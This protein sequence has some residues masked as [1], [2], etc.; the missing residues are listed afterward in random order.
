VVSISEAWFSDDKLWNLVLSWHKTSLLLNYWQL[1]GLLPLLS[2]I[3]WLNSKR[4][5]S[6]LR[7]LGGFVALSILDAFLDTALLLLL[8]SYLLLSISLRI[9]EEWLGFALGDH[10]LLVI[11][12]ELSWK[13]R[14]VLHVH[15]FVLKHVLVPVIVDPSVELWLL[16]LMSLIRVRVKWPLSLGGKLRLVEALWLWSLNEVGQVSI[17]MEKRRG[18]WCF[19]VTL[20]KLVT[21]HRLSHLA[22][23]LRLSIGELVRHTMALRSVDWL[24]Q[25]KGWIVWVQRSWILWGAA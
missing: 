2:W 9:D 20:H 6:P 4:S 13:N 22:R 8:E 11:W 1:N 19:V 23:V 21:V 5:L 18:R 12:L 10:E 14:D 3:A 17:T 15:A 25:V 24:S 16:K 7:L